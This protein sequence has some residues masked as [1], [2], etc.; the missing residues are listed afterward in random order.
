MESTAIKL[1][2]KIWHED[3]AEDPCDMDGWKV[4]SFGR[5][6]YN[7]KEPDEVGF[8]LNDDGDLVPGAELRAKLEAGF[9]FFLSYYEHGGCLWS[10]Q[11]ELPPGAN[12]PWD[13]VRTAG[14]LVWEWDEADLSYPGLRDGE[15]F[16]KRRGDARRFIERYTYWCNGEVYGYTI[17]AVR[18]CPSCGKDEEAEDHDLDLISCGGFYPNDLEWMVESMQNSIGDDWQD[19]DVEFK[20]QHPYGVAEECERLWQE[21]QG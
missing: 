12:C 11:N 9:A 15:V 8:E 21:G 10:L 3:M 18:P 20:E 5:R 13:S 17:D 16:L 4:H 14:L 6:H 7:H 2:V 19:Y 1:I